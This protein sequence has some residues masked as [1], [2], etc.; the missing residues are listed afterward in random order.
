MTPP[1][2]ATILIV[3]DDEAVAK[4]FERVLTVGGYRVLIALSAKEALVQLDLNRPDAIIMDLRMPLVDGF[5][6]LYRIRSRDAQQHLP[7]L[8]VTG[9]TT[10]TEDMLKE[11]SD[12]GGKIRY[13]PIGA[14]DLLAETRS[15]LQSN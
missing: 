6:L 12:L 8:V 5:G 14:A 7:V 3:D 9:D 13:K 4:T 2:D 15:L 11:L 1:V 10:L